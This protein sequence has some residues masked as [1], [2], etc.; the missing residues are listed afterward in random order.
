MQGEG[1]LL[2]F[3]CGGG[4]FLEQMQ[5]V[6]WQVTGVDI[7]REAVRHLRENLGI[8]A[9]VG[10][11]PHP[12]L[13]SE[14]FDVIT[15]WHSLEHVHWPRQVLRAAFDLLVPGGKLILAVPNIDS[16]PFRWFGTSWYGLDLPRHL[17]HFTPRSLRLML[18]E[19]QFQIHCLRMVRH[20]SW[21]RMSARQA[22]QQGQGGAGA[23]LLLL[24]PA[25]RL[26]SWYT[27]WKRQ[28][29]CI[30]AV[31]VKG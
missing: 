26:V 31:A 19:S 24:K 6:G 21:L 2:D 13:E 17:T 27:C 29:D 22:I 12:Q 30:M 7:C 23:R 9:Y 4:V 18:E 20:S 16:L 5:R 3:G 14:K 8:N 15:M 1:R 28:A 11:L 10:S 25:S